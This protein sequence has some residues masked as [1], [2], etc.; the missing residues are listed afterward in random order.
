MKNKDV[1]RLNRDFLRCPGG[2]EDEMR[3]GFGAVWVAF[4]LLGCNDTVIGPDKAIIGFWR[5]T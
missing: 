5:T 4:L 2:S 3:R 1:E